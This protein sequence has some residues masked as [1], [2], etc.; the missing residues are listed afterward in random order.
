M[1]KL[2]NEIQR[3]L[4][5]IHIEVVEDLK[6]GRL[7]YT[8]ISIKHRI[9]FSTVQYIAKKYGCKRTQLNAAKALV[10]AGQPEQLVTN[11]S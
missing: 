6:E 8:G 9:S 10:E 3:A 7:S 1:D 2:D 4:K 5:T 11:G